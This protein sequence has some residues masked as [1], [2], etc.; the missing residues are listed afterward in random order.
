M[1]QPLR[2]HASLQRNGAGLVGANLFARRFSCICRTDVSPTSWLLLFTVL[3]LTSG[4]WPKL[5]CGIGW[6][7]LPA[8]H[9]CCLGVRTNRVRRSLRM[10]RP[11]LAARLNLRRISATHSI[12]K[13]FF[14]RLRCRVMPAVRGTSSGV[15]GIWSWVRW[16]RQ[17]LM[18]RWRVALRIDTL[19]VDSYQPLREQASLKRNGAALV[20]ANLFARR[21]S[22]ICRTDVSPTRW[23]LRHCRCNARLALHLQHNL[24]HMVARFHIPMGVGHGRQGEDLVDHGFDRATG[25]LRPNVLQDPRDNG[26]FRGRRTVAQ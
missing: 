7:P 22:C 10:Q 4:K 21:F 16:R 12:N 8:L 17:L 9:S 24:P 1:Y 25:N 18:M 19:K 2:G 23:L 6:Q 20:G 5:I 15:P 13:R 14:L 3:C 26:C 11:G